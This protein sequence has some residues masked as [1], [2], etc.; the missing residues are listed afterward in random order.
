MTDFEE[1]DIE[2]LVHKVPCIIVFG[3]NAYAKAIVANHLFGKSLLPVVSNEI[4][5]WRMVRFLYGRVQ[6]VSLTLPGSYVLVDNLVANQK[7]WKTLPEDDLKVQVD[8]ND[9]SSTLE[10][11]N[12]A[13]MEVLQ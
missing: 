2:Q 1:S 11:S 10:S 7:P 8:R 3:Q 6:S 13:V 5:R 4:S 9:S 12:E